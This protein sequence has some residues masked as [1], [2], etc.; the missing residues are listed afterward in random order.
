METER[1]GRILVADDEVALQNLIRRK[2]EKHGLEILQVLNGSEVF[3]RVLEGAPDVILLD[4]NMPGADGRDVLKQLKADPR[5][6]DIPVVLYS[7]RGDPLDRRLGL[8]LGAEDYVEKPFDLDL[9]LQKLEYRIWKR[10][11]DR[12]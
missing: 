4:I 11:E 3:D 12:S 10:R 5:T 7:A 6:K 8:E 2:A 1:Q 9:L